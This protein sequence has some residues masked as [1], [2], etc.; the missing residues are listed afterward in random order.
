MEFTCTN[1]LFVI[2]YIYDAYIWI[3]SVTIYT[4]KWFVLRDMQCF[5]VI[6]LSL[7]VRN[8]SLAIRNRVRILNELLIKMRPPHEDQATNNAHTMNPGIIHV[9]NSMNTSDTHK[10]S[11]HQDRVKKEHWQVQRMRRIYARI[12]VAMGIYNDIFGWIYLVLYVVIVAYL[13]TSCNVALVYGIGNKK[14]GKADFG[15]ALLILCVLWSALP[16]VSRR[17]KIWKQKH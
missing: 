5:H 12:C 13:L 6:I 14:I 1:V 7:V 17:N 15:F 4:Y 11:N 10:K 9:M 3:D 16:L 8:Y 2:Y